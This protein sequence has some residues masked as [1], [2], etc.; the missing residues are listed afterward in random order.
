MNSIWSFSPKISFQTTLPYLRTILFIFGLIFFL[1][2]NLNLYNL[3]YL[4]SIICLLFLLFDSL[5]QYLFN[6][7]IFNDRKI[8]GSRISSLFGDKLIMGSYVSRLLPVIIGLSF[9]INLKKVDVSRSAPTVV[10]TRTRNI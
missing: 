2:K 1:K 5:V 4:V 7:N 10:H 9:I 3:F 8:G 6:Y